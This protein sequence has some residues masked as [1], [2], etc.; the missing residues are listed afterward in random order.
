MVMV[1][2]GASSKQ[3]KFAAIR[4]PLVRPSI[5]NIVMFHL[6]IIF[7][8]L[9]APYLAHLTFAIATLIVRIHF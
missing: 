2:N 4:L 8:M 9:S 3:T 6:C 5:L 1:I 7:Q